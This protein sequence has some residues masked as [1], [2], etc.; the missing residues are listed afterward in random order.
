M[1][2]SGSSFTVSPNGTSTRIRLSLFGETMAGSWESTAVGVNRQKRYMGY[3]MVTARYHY[4][5]WHDWDH[6]AGVAGDLIAVELYDQQSDPDE[7]INI[8]N[9]VENRQLVRRLSKQMQASWPNGALRPD[10]RRAR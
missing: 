7:N 2:V 8:A 3:S 4:V 9:L 6:E 5:Q 1:R 10:A